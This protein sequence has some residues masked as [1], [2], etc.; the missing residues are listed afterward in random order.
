MTRAPSLSCT[1][2]Y[3]LVRVRV[4]VATCGVHL[5]RPLA[6]YSE[7]INE[8]THRRGYTTSCLILEARGANTVAQPALIEI[9][10]R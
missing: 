10:D 7:Q 8:R 5:V 3:P 1:P 9:R 2:I 6:L 4:R